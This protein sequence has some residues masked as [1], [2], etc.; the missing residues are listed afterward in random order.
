MASDEDL[1]GLVY[2]IREHL[3]DYTPSI[4]FD[5]GAN[6]GTTARVLAKHFPAA[7]I[8]AF[9]PISSTY[10]RLSAAMA[11][12]PNA[13]PVQLALGSKTTVAT[14]TAVPEGLGNRM[15]TQE[16]GSNAELQSI[17]VETAE[18]FCDQHGISSVSLL[19]IDTEG[20]DL[21]VIKGFGSLL[22]SVDFVQTE[23]SMNTY[24]RAHVPFSSIFNH[25]SSNGFHLFKIYNQTMEFQRG[26]R[27]VLRRADPVFINARLVRDLP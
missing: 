12:M 1:E 23:V 7:R 9:E 25:L 26:G 21:E 15:V 3:P 16:R 22:S 13:T 8:F 4:I 19:K 11:G 18:S 10:A 24:N 14:M 2:D 5:V 17:H 20:H 6:I 27:P